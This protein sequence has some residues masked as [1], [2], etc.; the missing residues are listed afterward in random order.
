MTDCHAVFYENTAAAFDAAWNGR[1]LVHIGS[2]SRLNLDTMVENVAQEPVNPSALRQLVEAWVAAPPEDNR[3]IVRQ[4]ISHALGEIAV[5]P[6]IKRF[7]TAQEI[8]GIG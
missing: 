8:N 5:T 3:A 4:R 7:R 2:Q 1:H 6:L